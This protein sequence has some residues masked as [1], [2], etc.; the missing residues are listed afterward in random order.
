[1]NQDEEI[2]SL[3][4]QISEQDIDWSEAKKRLE[5]AGF[6]D[7]RVIQGDRAEQHRSK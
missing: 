3:L 7:V 2:E 5:A 1:M 4:E 6:T